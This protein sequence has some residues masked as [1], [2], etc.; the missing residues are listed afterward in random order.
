MSG[1]AGSSQSHSPGRSPGSSPSRSPG[2]SRCSAARRGAAT[3]SHA[4]A[5]TL[6]VHALEQY[7]GQSHTLRAVELE[8]PEGECTVLMGRNGVGKTTLLQCIVG[9]LPIRAGRVSLGGRDITALPTERRAAAGMGYV[10]QGRQIFPL[11]TVEE[12]LAIGLPARRDGGRTVPA[13]VYELFPVLADMRSRRGGGPVGRTA[14]AARDR[15]GARDRTGG[16]DPRRADRGHPAER[17]RRDRRRRAPAST[18]ELGL[19]GAARR[20]ETARSRG[21]WAIRF[22]LMDRGHIVARGPMEA[23]D[24]ELVRAYLTV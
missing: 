18:E 24:E 7:H 17:G 6:A 9:L 11:L 10:P 2:R 21:A 1:S 3:A 16:A 5:P 20:A 15:A 8:V 12:N 23:L 4:A 14:A 19:D 22:A 13:E